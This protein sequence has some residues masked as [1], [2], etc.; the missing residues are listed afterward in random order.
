MCVRQMCSGYFVQASGLSFSERNDVLWPELS[1]PDKYHHCR[2][3]VTSHKNHPG[4]SPLG[5]FLDRSVVVLFGHG[6]IL[7]LCAFW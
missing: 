4:H 5:Y 3:V 2:Q 6:P 7:F 1:P